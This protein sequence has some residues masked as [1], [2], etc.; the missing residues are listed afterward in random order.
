MELVNIK[1][2]LRIKHFPSLSRMNQVHTYRSRT[3]VGG[4]GA[5]GEP[6]T[7]RELIALLG[8]LYEDQ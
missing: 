2:I 8:I 4:E 3:V 6:V 7:H 5:L 1:N